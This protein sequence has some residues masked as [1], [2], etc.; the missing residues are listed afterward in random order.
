MSAGTNDVDVTGLEQSHSV[1]PSGSVNNNFSNG[2]PLTCDNCAGASAL[3]LMSRSSDVCQPATQNPSNSDTTPNSAAVGGITAL[4]E[5]SQKLRVMEAKMRIMQSRVPHDLYTSI[6][7][8][9]RVYLKRGM[10]REFWRSPK[11]I[12]ARRSMD[13]YDIVVHRSALT[14]MRDMGIEKFKILAAAIHNTF[15]SETNS[16]HVRFFPSWDIIQSSPGFS[17]AEIVF[18]SS[19]LLF[20]ALGWTDA[21]KIAEK[22]Y[23][24]HDSNGKCLQIVG[25]LQ[26]V[27]CE[28][29]DSGELHTAL[30]CFPGT[31]CRRNVHTWSADCSDDPVENVVWFQN[32]TWDT[33][34]NCLSSSPQSITHSP[35]F[36]IC[37]SCDLSAMKKRWDSDIVK[38]IEVHLLLSET[39][40]GFAREQ[41]QF[42]YPW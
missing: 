27:R 36:D 33:E 2:L 8:D 30:E 40:K 19:R 9:C 26:K 31:S 34:N 15:E 28:Q 41:L 23:K 4:S 24:V 35:G 37:P 25:G 18:S 22:M 16:A 20:S 14:T 12:V 32:A 39:M 7:K 38:I 13:Y 6:L 3:V 29:N 10:K 17:Q 42:L 5:L 11:K 21:E 1:Q